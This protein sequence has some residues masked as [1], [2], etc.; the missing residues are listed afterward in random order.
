[1]AKSELFLYI[2]IFTHH[3]RYPGTLGP[4]A[5]PTGRPNPKSRRAARKRR[6]IIGNELKRHG[7]PKKYNIIFVRTTASTTNVFG[8]Y[9]FEKKTTELQKK[10]EK[11]KRDRQEEKN[12]TTTTGTPRRTDLDA[13]G[14]RTGRN[15]CGN[16]TEPNAYDGYCLAWREPVT[17][18]AAVRG[19][20]LC[21][22]NVRSA[23]R[24]VSRQSRAQ[25]HQYRPTAVAGASA[26][27]KQVTTGKQVVIK[28]WMTMTSTP[29]PPPSPH[30]LRRRRTDPCR[31][32]R[33]V[34]PL[35]SR[36]RRRRWRLETRTCTS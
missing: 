23:V 24:W 13:R 33:P 31:C 36:R 10:S 18:G 6:V 35:Y 32:R 11:K 21:V 34:Q 20:V 8:P 5:E 30:R 4:L 22:Y 14:A 16:R 27:V 1:M 17:F 26:A 28:E 29:P 3:E 9:W 15:G 7:R 25:R 19:C 12:T 2:I